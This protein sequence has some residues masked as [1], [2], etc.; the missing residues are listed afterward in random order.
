[1]HLATNDLPITEIGA[2]GILAYVLI[3]ECFSG[4]RAIMDRRNGRTRNAAEGI[5][6][7]K[8]ALGKYG[9]TLATMAERLHH[10]QQALAEMRAGMAQTSAQLSDCQTRLTR[11]EAQGKHEAE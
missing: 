3:K 6:E 1:M 11:L 5:T 10:V 4:V 2:G 8:N 7:I 9:T